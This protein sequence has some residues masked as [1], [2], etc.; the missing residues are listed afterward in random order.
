MHDIKAKDSQNTIQTSD[1]V[2]IRII[3]LAA[4]V[5]TLIE[6]YDFFVYGSLATTLASKFYQTGT[7]D[8]GI[9]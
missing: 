6:W 8:G 9:Y 5:G 1:E 4:A 3:I 7:T 2:S